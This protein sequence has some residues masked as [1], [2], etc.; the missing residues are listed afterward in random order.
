[1]PFLDSSAL[2]T[3]KV[4][5]NPKIWVKENPISKGYPVTMANNTYMMTTFGIKKTKGQEDDKPTVIG[6]VVEELDRDGNE[7]GN[8]IG[9][10]KGDVGELRNKCSSFPLLEVVLNISKGQSINTICN[11]IPFAIQTDRVTKTVT[12]VDKRKG[13]MIE[14]EHIHKG[15][16]I[17]FPDVGTNN[18]DDSFEDDSSSDYEEDDDLDDG[19]LNDEDDSNCSVVDE[20]E[21]FK[22]SSEDEIDKYDRMYAGCIMWEA[23]GDGEVVL[24]QGNL[25]EE[26]K[27]FLDVFRDYLGIIAVIESMFPRACRRICVVHF[28]GSF[29]KAFQGPKL[30][31]LM[32]RACNAYNGWTH[33]KAMEALHN[34]SPGAHNWLL[35][36]SKEHWCRHLFPTFTKSDDN[37]INFVETLNNVLKMPYP[38]PL[39]SKQQM[40]DIHVVH[41]VEPAR[42]FQSEIKSKEED[43]PNSGKN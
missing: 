3:S 38:M 43:C 20:D 33:R 1:M 15:K 31:A 18:D 8:G 19:S 41:S 9:M 12:R 25:F 36:E 4:A 28:Q 23:K 10:G 24:K 16:E 34:L 32:T 2:H 39:Q 21:L 27:Q 17:M 26:K 42:Y 6:Q 40:Q 7:D 29:V 37:T 13:I 35:D 14:E 30:K 11:P 5:E 22:H